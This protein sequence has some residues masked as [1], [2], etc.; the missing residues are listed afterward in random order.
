MRRESV[1]GSLVV[2]AV[3]AARRLRQ[4]GRISPEAMQARLGAEALELLESKIEVASWYPVAA[5]CELIE[6]AWE[7]AGG[8]DPS[9]LERQGAE[10]ADRLFDSGRYQ[11]LEYAERSR[12]ADSR[13]QLIRSARL[14]TTITGAFYDFLDVKVALEQDRLSLVYGNARAFGDPL[15]H[16]TVGFK[17]QINV[18]QGSR[19][20]WTG[21]RTRPDEV[22]FHMPLPRRLVD[23]S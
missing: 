6:L 14:I 13:D 19:K 22:R 8:R 2:G 16:T 12:K 11:Q 20:R 3:V 23:A 18:R 7:I 15:I 21:E 9:Y 10:S 5:F 17:N 1:K 4:A